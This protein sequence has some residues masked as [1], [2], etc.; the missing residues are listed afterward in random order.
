[1]VLVQDG[2]A[3]VDALH[4][5]PK[6]SPLGRD[7]IQLEKT[8]F[9]F[10]LALQHQFPGCLVMILRADEHRLLRLVRATE[11]IQ[12]LPY[13]L[14]IGRHGGAIVEE[15]QS[16]FVSLAER[17]LAD[18]PAMIRS[19]PSI[20]DVIL[21]FNF[22]H[23]TFFLLGAGDGVMP[24]GISQEGVERESMPG[25]VLLDVILPT[26]KHRLLQRIET[27]VPSLSERILC[28][29]P[30]ALIPLIVQKRIIE[31]K[32]DGDIGS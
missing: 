4:L 30:D 1:M 28:N 19:S 32:V 15:F 5:R 9:D 26:V 3:V 8:E 2:D 24:A 14:V 22:I 23:S 11:R 21:D 25:I 20:N 10:F 16:D 7:I 17:G 18:G 29:P 31:H 13:F 12:Y 27:L 6:F